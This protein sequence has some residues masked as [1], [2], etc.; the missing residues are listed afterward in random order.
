MNGRKAKLLRKLSSYKP[1]D[2]ETYHGV[3]DTVR[4]REVRDMSGKVTYKHT[5]GTYQR[6]SSARTMYQMLKKAK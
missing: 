1:S 2:T 3:E 5:T 6:N 4:D